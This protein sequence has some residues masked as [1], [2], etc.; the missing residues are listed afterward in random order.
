MRLKLEDERQALASFVKKFDSLST[1][2]PLP[3]LPITKL[4]PPMP[5]PGGAAAVFAQRQRS[6]MQSLDLDINMS[7][8]TETDSPIRLGATMGADQSLLD[9]EW[10]AILD[11]SFG[12]E[13]SKAAMASAPGKRRS[14]APSSPTRD[15]FC[16][17]EN[18]PA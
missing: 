4:N 8:V 16:E 2:L 3:S 9:E 5:V 14:V 17:K 13:A 12:E 6:R 18:L 7:T 11:V 1:A 15:V 10:D